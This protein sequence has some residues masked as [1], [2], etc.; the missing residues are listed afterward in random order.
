MIG[1]IRAFRYVRRHIRPIH[2]EHTRH[3]L[4]AAL[5]SHFNSDFRALYGFFVDLDRN[6]L[7]VH[8]FFIRIII[9]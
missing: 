7:E 8:L 3:F 2:I 9:E 5:L 1:I 6:T 4:G